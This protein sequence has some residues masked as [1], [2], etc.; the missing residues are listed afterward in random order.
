[1]SAVKPKEDEPIDCGDDFDDEE[2]G[3]EGA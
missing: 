1:M 3:D 2:V